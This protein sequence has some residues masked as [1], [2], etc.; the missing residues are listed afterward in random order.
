LAALV[1]HGAEDLKARTP[2][3]R[4]IV[5]ASRSQLRVAV[6]FLSALAAGRVPLLIDPT[7][8]ERIRAVG[9]RFD[10][11]VFADDELL[12]DRDRRA[13]P[14]SLTDR[15]IGESSECGELAV[16][17][18]EERDEAFWVFTSGS[19]GEPKAVVHCHRAPVAA[20]DAFARN[21]LGLGPD[22]VTISTAGLPFVYALGNNLLFPLIAGASCD[23]PDDLL[24][25]TVLGALVR[26]RS[27][28]LVSGPWSLEALV[29][30]VRRADR[31]QAIQNLRLVLSAGEPLP[32]ALFSQWKERFGKEL[33]DNLGCTEMFNSFLSNIPGDAR[34]ASLGRGLHGF[35]IEVGGAQPRSGAK[36][37]LRVRGESRAVAVVE[38]R[39][40]PVNLLPDAWCDSGDEVAVDAEGRFLFLGRSDDRFKVKG[41]FVYPLEV[42]RCL[43]EVSGVRECLVVPETDEHGIAIVGARIVADAVAP[44]GLPVRLL[45]HARKRLEPF[46]V[47]E[48]IVVV[49]SLPRSARGK[50]E[51]PRAAGVDLRG[52]SL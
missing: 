20:F 50:L 48:R 21:V 4:R 35:E 15:W 41:Q 30:L 28:V 13:L 12:V 39:G 49:D 8:A 2:G 40:G 42:E 24:L 22:D 9:R 16:P 37:R 17:P 3:R 10:A 47:P 5:I 36:G 11:A 51:R 29:R 31:L 25:T 14:M 1:S 23:L 45:Q 38:G 34:S 26:H 18:A 44:A 52:A 19:T 32:A 7:S 33:I 6:G 27:T 43:L 46:Q